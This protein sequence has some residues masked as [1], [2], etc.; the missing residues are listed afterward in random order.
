MPKFAVECYY[1][2]KYRFYIWRFVKSCSLHDTLLSSSSSIF[3]HVLQL[4][5]VSNPDH[6]IPMA[7]QCGRVYLIS[8]KNPR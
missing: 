3:L 1:L 5:F 7:W 6:H 8:I 2:G 4:S